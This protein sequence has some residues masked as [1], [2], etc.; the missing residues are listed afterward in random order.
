LADTPFL[1]GLRCTCPAI[2]TITHHRLAIR[3]DLLTTRPWPLD[4]LTADGI[5]EY[6]S[7]IGSGS[8]RV[9]SLAARGWNAQQSAWLA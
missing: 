9:C 4:R 7:V 5:G 1:P 8:G 2:Y 6:E 3:D